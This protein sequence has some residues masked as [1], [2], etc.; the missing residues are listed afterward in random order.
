MGFNHG[1]R[2]LQFQN[3]FTVGRTSRQRKNGMRTQSGTPRYIQ[4]GVRLVRKN[5]N[6]PQQFHDHVDGKQHREKLIQLRFG[7]LVGKNRLANATKPVEQFKGSHED[8]RNTIRCLEQVV[9]D[10]SA[11]TNPE[12]IHDG[13]IRITDLEQPELQ[14]MSMSL[15]TSEDDVDMHSIDIPS[16]PMSLSI[17]ENSVQEQPEVQWMRTSYGKVRMCSIHLL[18]WQ[19]G[20]VSCWCCKQAKVMQEQEDND[21][22]KAIDIPV[23]PTM[24]MEADLVQEQPELH[25]FNTNYGKLQICSIHGLAWLYTQNC[26]CCED[27]KAAFDKS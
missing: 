23:E 11:N 12:F 8:I 1:I 19:F 27:A 24:G 26:K 3:S 20:P 16:D 7:H 22:K 2:K 5:I 25:W 9:K 14:P 13:S 21:S 18:D 10:L 6:G 15:N 4:Y 17:D